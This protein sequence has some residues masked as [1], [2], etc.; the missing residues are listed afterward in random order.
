MFEPTV[1]KID[2]LL[3]KLVTLTLVSFLKFFWKI[4]NDLL[5]KLLLIF[6]SFFSW[7]LYNKAKPL[8]EK[9]S[10]KIGSS[11][12]LSLTF[13]VVQ[14]KRM[15]NKKDIYNNS[16]LNLFFKLHTAKANLKDLFHF[17]IN[18]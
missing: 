2:L 7:G 9:A 3:I 4:I 5:S 18:S 12:F 8:F 16:F 13:V 10:L 14:E 17:N 15:K 1:A 11:I 6:L